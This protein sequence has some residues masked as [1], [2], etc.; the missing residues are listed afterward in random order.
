MR[1][2]IGAIAVSLRAKPSALG[3]SPAGYATLLA[4][5]EDSL[6]P[7]TSVLLAGDPGEAAAWRHALERAYRPTVRVFDVAGVTGLPA[8]LRKGAVDSGA[9]TAWICRGTHCLPPCS[10]L[11]ETL[12]T[13]G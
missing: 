10:T 6:H 13:L 12:R 7:P 11:A 8:T 2:S 3:R 4:A 5:L 1:S 9:G